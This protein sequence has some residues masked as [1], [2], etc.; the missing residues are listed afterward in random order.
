MTAS[1]LFHC[2]HNPPPSSA[3]S[4]AATTTSSFSSF[5]TKKPAETM[6]MNLREQE[7]EG[8]GKNRRQSSPGRILAES[9]RSCILGSKYTGSSGN[10]AMV[11]TMSQL[12]PPVPLALEVVM[13]SMEVK[14]EK[15]ARLGDDDYCNDLRTTFH[16]TLHSYNRAC[17]SCCS[18]GIG[19]SLCKSCISKS[20]KS[21]NGISVYQ[22]L[23]RYHN[24]IM[25]LDD[26]DKDTDILMKIE[27]KDNEIGE[28]GIENN[29]S[30]SRFHRHDYGVDR[31]NNNNDNNKGETTSIWQQRTTPTI[32]EGRNTSSSSIKHSVHSSR[33]MQLYPKVLEEMGEQESDEGEEHNEYQLKRHHNDEYNSLFHNRKEACSAHTVTDTYTTTDLPVI[34]SFY[35]SALEEATLTE[36]EE[37]LLLQQQQ[38]QSVVDHDQRR[39]QHQPE[40]GNVIATINHTPTNYVS[41]NNDTDDIPTSFTNKK[42]KSSFYLSALEKTACQEEFVEEELRLQ[43]QERSEEEEYSVALRTSSEMYRAASLSSSIDGDHISLSSS[44]SSHRASMDPGAMNSQIRCYQ[45]L[46]DNSTSSPAVTRSLAIPF[47]TTSFLPTLRE[48]KTNI[49]SELIAKNIKYDHTYTG[50]HEDQDDEDEGL[51]L[52]LETS[53]HEATTAA[54]CSDGISSCSLSTIEGERNYLARI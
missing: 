23:L 18:T 52:V 2:R 17:S 19:S 1:S 21:S 8:R 9:M 43:Q 22:A 42:K 27:E 39:N 53:R 32:R 6:L 20:S 16:S 51:R 15:A 36:E 7:I 49:G 34:S 37:K 35:L 24:E 14:V 40:D 33:S 30:N 12:T 3:F 29:H 11:G 48:G 44:S 25:V 50:N 41:G 4:T 31:E 28:L 45:S 5:S 13:C 47:N 54:S 26:E 10:T 38:D 46:D